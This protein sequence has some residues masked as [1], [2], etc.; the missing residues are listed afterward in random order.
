M[1]RVDIVSTDQTPD[2][3]ECGKWWTSCPRFATAMA[4]LMIGARTP[5]LIAPFPAERQ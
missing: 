1:T 5:T 4:Q 2:S 3:L